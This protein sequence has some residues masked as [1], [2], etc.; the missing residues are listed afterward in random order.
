MIIIAAPH[1]RHV[2][3]TVGALQWMVARG[4][5]VH[6][7]RMRQQFSDLGKNRARAFSVI[8]D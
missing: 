6:A 1:R 5:T 3:V 7:A 8:C 4:M 2:H